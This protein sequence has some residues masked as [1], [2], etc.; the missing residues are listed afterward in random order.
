[1][2]AFIIENSAL[3]FIDCGHYIFTNAYSFNGKKRFVG[4][5]VAHVAGIYDISSG[6]H[7]R[8]G[9]RVYP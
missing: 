6:I 8:C 9:Y 3:P 5:A 7:L 2:V 1:M 4:L